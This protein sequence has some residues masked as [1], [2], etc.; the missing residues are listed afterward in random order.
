MTLKGSIAAADVLDF[1][2]SLLHIIQKRNNLQ[3]APQPWQLFSLI[4]ASG[5][6]RYAKDLSQVKLSLTPHSLLAMLLGHYK[7]STEECR[8]IL[9]YIQDNFCRMSAG[10]SSYIAW[11]SF[12]RVK[13]A[14]GELCDDVPIQ[15]TAQEEQCKVYGWS[16][17][18]VQASLS[19]A[20]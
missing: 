4:C 11:F 16:E 12:L 15:N 14:L 13:R 8:R 10:P 6:P 19:A 7:R 1:L 9:P 20:S 2:D 5:A 3:H 17:G 18:I